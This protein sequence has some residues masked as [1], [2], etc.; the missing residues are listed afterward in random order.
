MKRIY[1][2]ALRGFVLLAIAS[3]LLFAAGRAETKY[4]SEAVCNNLKIEITDSK[5]AGFITEEMV[6]S[7]LSSKSIAIVGQPI[8]QINTMKVREALMAHTYVSSAAVYKTISGDVCI[9]LTQRRPMLRF[10][11]STGR[12]SYI[13]NDG[14]LV[15]TQLQYSVDVPIVT[16]ELNLPADGQCIYQTD[17]KIIE[18]KSDKNYEFLHKL[19]NFV[20]F[21]ESDSDLR[22]M[23]V[24]INITKDNEL[25]LIPRVGNHAVLLGTIDG[26]REKLD[27]LSRFYA[28][29]LGFDGWNKYKTINLKFKNQVICSK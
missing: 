12:S 1:K 18:K 17:N 14:W 5:R 2:I 19:I 15:P 11:T 6:R 23:F 7:W 21:L 8:G 13:T 10:M 3:Y 25:E 9:E 16:G 22:K 29:G 26:Y 4:D 20:E 24:Q 27:K 28:E